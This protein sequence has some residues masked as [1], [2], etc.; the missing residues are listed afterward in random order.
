MEILVKQGCFL[1]YGGAKWGLRPY[2]GDYFL[3]IGCV[4]V[5]V[6]GVSLPFFYRRY[7]WTRDA[8]KWVSDAPL[9]FIF[10]IV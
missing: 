6:H 7:R 2:L 4:L 3:Q 10:K 5:V 9:L 1:S 8:S